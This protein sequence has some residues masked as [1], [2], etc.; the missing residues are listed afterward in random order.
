MEV[1]TFIT[2]TRDLIERFS[3]FL[4]G[5]DELVL[6]GQDD[7]TL[8]FARRGTN[9]NEIYFHFLPAD[10]ES[11]FS[12]NYNIEEQLEIKRFLDSGKLSAFD[13]QFRDE[14]FL[15][16]LLKDFKNYLTKQMH[17]SSNE[18]IIISHPHKGANTVLSL[19]S[20][21]QVSKTV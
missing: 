11:E 21:V 13:I 10:I 19:R 7:D 20:A 3:S 17:L 16:Q 4:K 15:Q 18:I 5:H 9:R 12:Y 2:Q 8:Y 1:L 6:K 14:I